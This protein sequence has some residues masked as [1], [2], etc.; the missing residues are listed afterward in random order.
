M[1]ATG[2]IVLAIGTIISKITGL[3]NWII[4]ISLV[5]SGLFLLE[6]LDLPN[7]SP[8][9]K[10]KTGL[11]LIILSGGIFGFIL[12]P[13]TMAFVLPLFAGSFSLVNENFKLGLLL[14]TFFSIGH[15]L[16]L[17]SLGASFELVNSWTKNHSKFISIFKKILG[18][19]LIIFGIYKF[20]S[21]N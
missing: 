18:T 8:H 6:V 10:N 12:G 17:Y 21:L 4:A 2:I 1:I 20:Y 9:L 14:F 16:T 13:C 15:V 5:L 19:I 7:P 3:S 11:T